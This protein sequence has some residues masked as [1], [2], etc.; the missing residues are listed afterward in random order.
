MGVAMPLRMGGWLAGWVDQKK[1]A[2]SGEGI[3]P[4]EIIPRLKS[5]LLGRIDTEF[6]FNKGLESR[7]SG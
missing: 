6:G 4:R 7:G 5:S 1:T 3:A 2:R